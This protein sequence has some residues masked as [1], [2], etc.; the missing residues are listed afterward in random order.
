MP[1]VESCIE[2]FMCEVT[3][4]KSCVVLEKSAQKPSWKLENMVTPTYSTFLSKKLTLTFKFI[5]LSKL[6]QKKN[7]NFLHRDFLRLQVN[8]F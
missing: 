5:T 1:E 6:M 2:D 4:A 8:I 7:D 3:C